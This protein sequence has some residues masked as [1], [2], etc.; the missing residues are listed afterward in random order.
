MY[1]EFQV[2]GVPISIGTSPQ[3]EME[4]NMCFEYERL[5]ELANSNDCW[6]QVGGQQ[7]FEELMKYRDQ[8]DQELT[9]LDYGWFLDAVDEDIESNRHFK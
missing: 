2:A 9:D 7:N 8:I 5:A 6:D 1:F 4:T 3:T